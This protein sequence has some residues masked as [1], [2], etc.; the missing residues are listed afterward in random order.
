MQNPNGYKPN[1]RF[2]T[3]L[4]QYSVLRKTQT[5][6]NPNMSFATVQIEGGATPFLV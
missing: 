3:D 4:E 6:T 5:D 1:I 2:A